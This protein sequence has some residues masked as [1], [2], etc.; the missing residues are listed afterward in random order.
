[1]PKLP[2]S[3]VLQTAM[4]FLEQASPDE[5]P[6]LTAVA[7]VAE[8]MRGRAELFDEAPLHRY[9]QNKN[10]SPDLRRAQR[11]MDLPYEWNWEVREW[12]KRQYNFSCAYCGRRHT[13]FHLDHI[14]PV[15]WE[16]CPGATLENA[17]LACASCNTDR[18]NKPLGAWLI[19]TFGPERAD[20]VLRKVAAVS[21]RATKVFGPQRDEL[22]KEG[23]AL[24]KRNWKKVAKG[25]GKRF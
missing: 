13:T 15:S 12:F 10:M 9:Y 16:N 11:D 3:T 20:E 23:K 21:K 4:R 8:T 2:V 5:N 7:V 1:M 22:R 6:L 24:T 18:S 19:E 17:V 14:I 25:K